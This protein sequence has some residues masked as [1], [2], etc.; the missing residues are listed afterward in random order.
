MGNW[1]SK[2]KKYFGIYFGKRSVL[3]KEYYYLDTEV[4]S[5]LLQM[6]R[7]ESTE[8]CILFIYDK[9]FN[10]NIFYFLVSFKI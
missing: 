1:D 8:N 5:E 2:I 4:L 9:V 6:S 10:I 3:A 7:E